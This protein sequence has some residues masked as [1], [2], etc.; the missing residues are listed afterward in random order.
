VPS[1]ERVHLLCKTSLDALFIVDDD[2]RFVRVN[3]PALRLL[4]AARDE[5]LGQ[6]IEHFTAPDQRSQL[7]QLAAALRRDGT[8]EGEY[9]VLRGNGRRSWVKFR[10]CYGFGIGKH[11][12]A[13]VERGRPDPPP[14]PAGSSGLTPREAEVLQLASYGY[15]THQIGAVLVVSPATVKTHFE[16]IYDKLEARDRTLAVAK[17]LRLG[18]IV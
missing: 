13:A 8:L 18:L 1:D 15:T 10:A 5:I 14:V 2:G 9:E 16:H 3:E 6:R 11:L 7:D 4:G 17:A 12:I